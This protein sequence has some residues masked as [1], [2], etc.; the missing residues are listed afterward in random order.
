[1]A[2]AADSVL[3]PRSASCLLWRLS[4]G[5]AFSA[6]S[7]SVPFSL[8]ENVMPKPLLACSRMYNLAPAVVRLWTDLF[9]YV[10]AKSGVPLEII[11]HAAP[12]PLEALWSRDD[13]GLVFLCGRP[14]LQ[15]GCRHRPVAAPVPTYSVKIC[16]APNDSTNEAGGA[17]Y[18]SLLSVRES[19]GLRSLEDCFGRTVGFMAAHSQSGYNALRARL[20]PYA[21]RRGTSR[22][23]ARAKGPYASP[24][25]VLAALNAGEIDLA[26]IDSYAFELY[27]HHAAHLVHGLCPIDATDWTAMPFLAASPGIDDET[28][29][30]LTEACLALRE[31]AGDVLQALGL[32]GFAPVRS[33]SYAALAAQEAAA[34]SEGYLSLA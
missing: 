18:R 17:I 5:H 2:L 21:L 28:V 34:V 20:A 1:M 15:Y 6:G 9:E 23:F 10:A 29:R 24:G 22:L 16:S 4:G 14:F 25:A 26:P 31:S 13:L 11:P 19:D 8:L 27:L 32:H 12:A 30:A 3:P 7:F 33:K